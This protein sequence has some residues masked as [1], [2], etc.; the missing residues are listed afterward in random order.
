AALEVAREARYRD[1][2][3]RSTPSEIRERYFVPVNPRSSTRIWELR[4]EIRKLVRFQYSNLVSGNQEIQELVVCRNVLIYFTRPQAELAEKRL[5]KTL[6]SGG[7]LM[8]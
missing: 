5:T 2:S 8:L 4:P 1:W 3:F 6:Q 7:W